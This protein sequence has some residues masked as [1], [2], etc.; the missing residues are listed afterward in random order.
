[1]AE[2]EAVGFLIGVMTEERTQ[3][4]RPDRKDKVYPELQDL[5]EVYFEAG[6]FAFQ[7]SIEYI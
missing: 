5:L 3:C 2:K 1:M 7:I 4:R 6:W